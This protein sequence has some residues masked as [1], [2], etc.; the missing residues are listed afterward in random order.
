MTTNYYSRIRFTNQL[1]PLLQAASPGLSRVVSV[2]GPGDE[3][4]SLELENLD[5]KQGFSIRKAAL[6]ATTMTDFAFEEAAKRH[7]VTSF[8]HTSPGGVNTAYMRDAGALVKLGAKLLMPLFSPWMVD[9]T[10]SGERHLYAA[11]S[12]VYPARDK[13]GGVEV[14]VELIKRGSHGEIGSGAYLIGSDGERRANDKGLQELRKRGAGKTIWQHTTE[15]LQS[16][17]G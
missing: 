5:L 7:T 3:S 4:N 1:L 16:T 10:E 13:D 12:G 9:I 15:L 11:T 2:L 6:H 14:G 8:V 17:R